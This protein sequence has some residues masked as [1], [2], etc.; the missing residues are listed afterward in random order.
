[1][2]NK[3]IRQNISALKI[4]RKSYL[5]KQ[6]HA[7]LRDKNN[8]FKY[9]LDCPLCANFQEDSCVNC[10]WSYVPTPNTEI[11]D[12]DRSCITWMWSKL[13]INANMLKCVA[14][15]AEEIKLRLELLETQLAWLERK[16]TNG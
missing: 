2:D 6:R 14:P 3:Q 9:L 11:D 10:I 12:K 8:D 7:Y 1:M 4:L 15:D 16:L 13:N 5:S